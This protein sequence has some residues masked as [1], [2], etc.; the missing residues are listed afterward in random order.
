MHHVQVR[1]KQALESALPRVGSHRHTTEDACHLDAVARLAQI[2]KL[3][4]HTQAQRVRRLAIRHNVR[5]L[6][7]ADHLAVRKLAPI[8]DE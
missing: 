5:C 4:V 6:L 2:H 8:V 1:L 3:V 7:E